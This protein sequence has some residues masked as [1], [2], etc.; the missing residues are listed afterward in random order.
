V[1]SPAGASNS[2]AGA[3]SG[4]LVPLY[5]SGLAAVMSV[6]ST[7]LVAPILTWVRPRLPLKR[8]RTEVD[9]GWLR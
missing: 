3:V 5:V 9:R 2:G 6:N 1:F 8:C 7:P 4:V